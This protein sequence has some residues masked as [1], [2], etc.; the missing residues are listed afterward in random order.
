[1]T[2]ALSVAGDARRFPALSIASGMEDL[3]V[4]PSLPGDTCLRVI[5]DV[6]AEKP[7]DGLGRCRLIR[8][9]D[10]ICPQVC[11]AGN[12]GSKKAG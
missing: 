12:L 4:P 8:T 3:Q 10:M 5:P 9:T 7:H 2:A 11:P 1:M 6:T